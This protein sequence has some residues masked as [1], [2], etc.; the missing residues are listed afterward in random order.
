[1]CYCRPG[2]AVSSFAGMSA[3]TDPTALVPPERSLRDELE[4]IGQENSSLVSLALEDPEK[5]LA[6]LHA[7]FAPAVNRLVYRLLGPD[8]EHED[9]VQQVFLQMIQSIGKLRTPERLSYWVRSVTIN[10]VRSELRSRT[11]R[12]AFLG[13]Y[14]AEDSRD[15]NDDLE[16]SSFLARSAAVLERMPTEERLVF[17]LFY[18]EETPLP[19][20]AEV[21]GFSTMTAKRR[22][23]KAR[24][25]FKK[26]M[27]WETT[28]RVLEMGDEES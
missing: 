17:T 27:N 21:C 11:V 6:A 15:L 16:S 22:L 7:R 12:R 1:M 5:G 18:L 28:S 4:R 19:E 23:S 13:W 25:R 10:I 3:R 26:Y 2:T 24:S 8:G 14:R 9:L 20:I